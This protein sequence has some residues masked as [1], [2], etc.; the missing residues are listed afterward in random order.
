MSNKLF[1]S[2]VTFAAIFAAFV[3][4]R[5]F[6]APTVTVTTL[7]PV[8]AIADTGESW[9][10][11][12]T[13]GLDEAGAMATAQA[14]AAVA[15]AQVGLD[16]V[17]SQLGATSAWAGGST[18]LIGFGLIILGA[19]AVALARRPA[20]APNLGAVDNMVVNH[21]RQYHEELDALHDKLAALE[22]SKPEV[23]PMRTPTEEQAEQSFAAQAANGQGVP[24]PAKK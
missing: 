23:T 11:P 18:L 1:Y 5:A 10:N 9:W 2:L 17:T 3:V 22:R 4:G 24:R 7:S 16:S 19:A 12:A 14:N 6:T 13:W 15:S 20:P 8:G 21:M